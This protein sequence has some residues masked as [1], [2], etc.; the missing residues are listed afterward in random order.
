D[1]SE[2]RDLMEQ[3]SGFVFTGWCGDSACEQ[4]VKDD[5]K[6]TIRVIPDEEFRS[7]ET[8]VRCLCGAPSVCEVVRARAY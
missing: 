5:T 3:L 1:Y 8:P 4:K 6:S 7:A 2:F